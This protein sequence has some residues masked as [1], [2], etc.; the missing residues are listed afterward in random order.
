MSTGI[1]R[2]KKE[3]L[4]AMSLDE[5]RDYANYLKSQH[6]RQHGRAGKKFD[7]PEQERVRLM[8]NISSMLSRL[9]RR[10]LDK[11]KDDYQ[12][13]ITS[14]DKKCDE[15]GISPYD[16]RVYTNFIK[17]YQGLR[18]PRNE[19]K[20]RTGLTLKQIAILQERTGLKPYPEVTMKEAEEDMQRRI[21]TGD[22]Y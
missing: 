11:K 14:D 10:Q 7:N 12:W 3:D 18:V 13:W 21:E 9:I 17:H 22:I 8:N 19:V 6:G 15:H 20:G 5:L 2:K 16:Q 1:E 4:N